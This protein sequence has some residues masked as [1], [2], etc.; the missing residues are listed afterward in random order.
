VALD[1]PLA[2]PDLD[3]PRGPMR[4]R[5]EAREAAKRAEE[6][7]ARRAKREADEA[8]YL[9]RTAA[10][11]AAMERRLRLDDN[12]YSKALDER[13]EADADRLTELLLAG[14]TDEAEALRRKC[15]RNKQLRQELWEMTDP[16][17]EKRRS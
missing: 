15:E 4:A 11:R 12:P 1:E 5:I 2:V 8:D 3:G 9:E 14:R 7:A 10:D 6:E 17:W 13:I 16:A